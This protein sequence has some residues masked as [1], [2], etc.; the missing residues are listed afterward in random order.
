MTLAHTFLIVIIGS[1][2]LCQ[3]QLY[4]NHNLSVYAATTYETVALSASAT[5]LADY[6]DLKLHTFSNTSMQAMC[7]VGYCR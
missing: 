5:R 3:P 4:G 7:T 1:M 6:N 2:R